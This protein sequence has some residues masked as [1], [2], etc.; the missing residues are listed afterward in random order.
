MTWVFRRVPP[1]RDTGFHRGFVQPASLTLYLKIKL[2]TQLAIISV[3][4]KLVQ[5]K[6]ESED[7]VLEDTW[8]LPA[9]D[10]S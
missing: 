9:R 5:Y 7:R 10:E 1:D 2:S 6:G 4:R 3:Q 8:N